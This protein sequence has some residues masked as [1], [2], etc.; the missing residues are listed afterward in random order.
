ME[1]NNVKRLND[2]Q[3]RFID[4]GDWFGCSQIQRHCKCSYNEAARVMQLG[5]EDGILQV[6]AGEPWR[7]RFIN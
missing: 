7:I 5:I 3:E 1:I 4:D 6:K 2:L